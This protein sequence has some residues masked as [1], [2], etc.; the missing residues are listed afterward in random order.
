MLDQLEDKGGIS[1]LDLNHI[2]WNCKQ[3]KIQTHTSSYDITLVVTIAH[4]LTNV[5]SLVFMFSFTLS[6][7]LARHPKSHLDWTGQIYAY[8]PE[9]K[10]SHLGFWY[11]NTVKNFF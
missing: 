10:M 7:A 9:F 6:A 5:T 8:A 2:L 3:T 4:K 1:K 11:K